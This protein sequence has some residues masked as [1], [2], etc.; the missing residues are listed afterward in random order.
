MHQP[1]H[2]A[3]GLLAWIVTH[4]DRGMQETFGPIIERVQKL[5]GGGDDGG[6]EAEEGG[7]EEEGVGGLEVG[8][9]GGY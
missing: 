5:L 7:D 1:R 4:D 3:S 2:A 8:Q 9:Q 6:G